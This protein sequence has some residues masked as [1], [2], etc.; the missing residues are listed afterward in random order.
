MTAPHLST[1]LL[2]VPHGFFGR[3]GGVSRGAMAS[4]QCG[5][6]ADDDRA[7]IEANRRIVAD[8]LM[9][10]AEIATV[11]QVHGTAVVRCAAP[12]APDRLP[13]A[14]ALVS[15]TP[16]LLIG[17]LTADCAPVLLADPAVGVVGAAHAGWKG[18][19]A[20]VTD[21]VIAGMEKLGAD[22][23]RIAAAVGPCIGLASYEVDDAFRSRFEA[24][25]LENERFFRDGRPGHARFD[26]EGYVSARLA[27]AGVTRI[28]CLSQDTYSQPERYFSY[29]RATH[30][31]EPSYGRQISV[32]GVPAR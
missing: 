19:L 27:A 22:C 15:D 16:G 30:R 9:P 26:L 8:S 2:G 14:D 4:L 17:I 28:R 29:R 18:A 32:I 10:G 23:T 24:A 21:A 3:E 31:D 20:G 13:Q 11:A 7:A 6:G 12:A 25:A 1:E 5:F